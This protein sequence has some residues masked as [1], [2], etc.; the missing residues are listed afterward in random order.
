MVDVEGNVFSVLVD[1]ISKQN[2]LMLYGFEGSENEV[3]QGYCDM[4]QVLVKDKFMLKVVV[5][6]VCCFWQ[7]MFN[8]DIKFNFGCGDIMKWFQCFMEFYLVFQQ[9]VQIDG[10]WISYVDLCYDLGV[11]VGWVFVFVEEIN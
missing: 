8:N 5:M 7:L 4:G 10:K 1:C 2:L 9:Q 11:V 6:I 3:L